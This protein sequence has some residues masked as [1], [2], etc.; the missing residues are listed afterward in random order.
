ML[1]QV[2]E[3]EERKYADL[4]F[5]HRYLGWKENLGVTKKT[6][7][8]GLHRPPIPYFRSRQRLLKMPP[9]TACLRRR[10][11]KLRWLMQ[12]PCLWPSCSSSSNSSNSKP[13][14]VSSRTTWSRCF[15]VRL[16]LQNREK[17]CKGAGI[18]VLMHRVAMTPAILRILV[19]RHYM[20]PPDPLLHTSREPS[21]EPVLVR[22][23][24]Q[25]TN[26][27]LIP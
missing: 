25:Q 1:F 14:E 19:R 12:R 23:Q 10:I 16:R 5:M 13:K 27:S 20:R 8:R 7:R 11:T 26:K 15:R 21:R 6:N 3:V 4:T 17:V 9:P 2:P 22:T 24:S 18:K